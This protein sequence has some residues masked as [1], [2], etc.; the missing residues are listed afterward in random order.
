MKPHPEA[1]GEARPTAGL[2]D[3]LAD[4]AIAAVMAR[5]ALRDRNADLLAVVEDLANGGDRACQAFVAATRTLP[6]WVDPA[7]IARG[8]RVALSV[9]VPTA[10][11]LLLG[12]LSEVYAVTDIA[13]ALGATG[14]LH[15]HTW[16]RMLETGRFLLDVH[17]PHGLRSEGRSLRSVFRVRLLHAM[18]RA[19]VYRATGRSVISQAQLAFT[20]CAHSHVVRR[21]LDALGCP[22]SATEANAHHHLWRIV[23]HAMGIGP[24]LLAP[25]VEAEAE[26]YLQLRAQLI[27]GRSEASRAL[28]RRSIAAVAERSSIP[29]TVVTAVVECLIGRPLTARLQLR[30]SPAY[31]RLVGV[32]IWALRGLG[33]L[34]RSV[35]M[36]AV[37]LAPLGRAFGALVVRQ[38]PDHRLPVG[39]AA[40]RGTSVDVQLGN[41]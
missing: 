18:V 39:V 1:A 29:P 10:T 9:V 26:L 2:G 38:D 28:V 14:R 5:G 36:L 34:R 31:R 19:K 24:Q 11:A 15:D 17:T 21:G 37:L 12:G 23:G 33:A 20:L 16:L 3:P 40:T 4:E 13:A 22:L 35:P 6:S 41:A 32:G 8:Q 7:A 27:D 30:V 25:S